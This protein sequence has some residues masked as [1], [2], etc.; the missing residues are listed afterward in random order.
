MVINDGNGNLIVEQPVHI[1]DAPLYPVRGIM[2]DTGRN[3]IS[4]KKIFEQIDGMALSKLNVL[5]WHIVD[6]QSWPLEVSAYPE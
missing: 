1:Q 6:S 4:K 3:F 2:I 5:H